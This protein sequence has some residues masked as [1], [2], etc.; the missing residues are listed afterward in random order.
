MQQFTV[1]LKRLPIQQ[2]NKHLRQQKNFEKALNQLRHQMFGFA[3]ALSVVA[4]VN[5]QALLGPI[6]PQTPS[7]CT[8]HF[9]IILCCSLFDTEHSILFVFLNLF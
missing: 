7:D 6:V 5:A 9:C 3:C 1:S 8:T 4:L 2:T